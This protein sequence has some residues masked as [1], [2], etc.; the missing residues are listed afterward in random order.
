VVDPPLDEL[1]RLTTP[2]SAWA[3]LPRW[4]SESIDDRADSRDATL[5]I[6]PGNAAWRR[7]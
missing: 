7:S 1:M 4:P 3:D 5:A 2:E 6:A